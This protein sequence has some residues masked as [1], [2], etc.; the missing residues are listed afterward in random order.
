MTTYRVTARRWERGWELHIEGMGVTQ[1]RRL[2][3]AEEMVRD[4]LALDTGADPDS[5]DVVITPVV[6]ADVAETRRAVEAAMRAQR[7]AAARS[8][9]TARRLR[10]LGLS[11]REIAMVLGVSPQRV[12]QLSKEQA[13]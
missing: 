5:L 11:G 8:R 13:S 9:A 12:S 3:E 6:D 2:T 1:C 4:Y 10:S 7:M